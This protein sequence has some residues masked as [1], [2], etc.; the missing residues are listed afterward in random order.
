[1][2]EKEH[3]LGDTEGKRGKDKSPQRERKSPPI[4]EEGRRKGRVQK[5]KNLGEGKKDS[6]LL[7]G[8]IERKRGGK[9]WPLSLNVRRGGKGEGEPS[10]KNPR[11]LQKGGR[12]KEKRRTLWRKGE[13][14]STERRSKIRRRVHLKKRWERGIKSNSYDRRKGGVSYQLP[15]L[16]AEKGKRKK[17]RLEEG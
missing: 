8:L 4:R 14:S 9:G 2:K 6:L 15:L 13:D 7:P 1:V 3:K 5:K 10:T 11:Q 17:I 12:R 16:E